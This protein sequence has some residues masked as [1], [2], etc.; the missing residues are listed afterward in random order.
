MTYISVCNQR[1]G[2]LV[3]AKA[4]RMAMPLHARVDI[5]VLPMSVHFYQNKTM[6]NSHKNPLASLET[7][8]PIQPC[9]HS[10]RLN[11]SR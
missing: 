10:V 4:V 2:K 9:R 8:Y 11:P 6:N 3:R 5:L 7:T 1:L